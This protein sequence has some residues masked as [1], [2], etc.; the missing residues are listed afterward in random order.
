MTRPPIAVQLNQALR[1][2]HLGGGTVAATAA[3][4]IEPP[5]RGPGPAVTDLLESIHEAVAELEA[6]RKNSLIE[7]QE[8]AV[9]LA[10]AAAGHVVRQ[11]LDQGQFAVGA[12]IDEMLQRISPH[13]PVRITLHPEDLRLLTAAGPTPW[14]EGLV[15]FR[16]DAS[17]PRGKCR[18]V[19]GS[20]TVI[21]DWRTHLQEA[22][23]ALHEELE[24][25]QIERRGAEAADQRVKRFPDR[26]ETA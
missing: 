21:S 20:R 13:E 11:A 5:P 26:R 8:V 3:P 7:L 1:K 10:M 6:R 2:I 17:T 18:A 15:E 12:I 25:A 24:H 23:A 22:R 4:A 9:E 16:P 19:A 14:P